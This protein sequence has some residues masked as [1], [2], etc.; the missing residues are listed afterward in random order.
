M[1]AP[2]KSL[3]ST[4]DLTPAERRE[5]AIAQTASILVRGLLHEQISKIEDAA[6][7]TAEDSETDDKPVV[8]KVSITID[9]PAGA[10]APDINASVSYALRRKSTGT[11]K[12]DAHQLKLEGVQ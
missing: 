12:A 5:L 11:L 6:A 7:Q 1:N 9:W 3:P 8:A 10:Q 4:E 2:L